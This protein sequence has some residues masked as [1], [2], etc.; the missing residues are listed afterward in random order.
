MAAQESFQSGCIAP[1]T[2][3]GI[4]FQIQIPGKVGGTFKSTRASIGYQLTANVHIRR[5]KEVFVLQHH[6]PVCLFELVQIRAAI[7]IASP[8]DLNP[9]TT[10]TGTSPSL[11]STTSSSP[12]STSTSTSTSNEG[13]RASGVRFVIPKS[14][15]VLGTAEVKPYS[16]WGLGPT[17]S[18]PSQIY[19]HHNYYRYAGNGHGYSYLQDQEHRGSPISSAASASRP[20]YS[21]SDAS[22]E[23]D[24]HH[25]E[26]IK[27]CSTMI[28]GKKAQLQT[29][30]ILSAG[31]QHRRLRRQQQREDQQQQKDSDRRYSPHRDS[32]DG[33]DEVGFGAHIDK[34]VA[35]AG[36]NITLGMFVVKSDGMKVI[37]IKVSLVETIQIFSL[38]DDD[39]G[40]REA[41][42]LASTKDGAGKTRQDVPRRRLVETHV[43][44]I[45]KDYVPAQA[46]ES[47]ANDNHLKGYYE[48]YEDFRS[49][50]SLSVYKLGMHIPETA[51][52]VLDR[53]LFKVEYMFVIKF[54]FKGRMGAF[55][56][57]PI[58][59]ISQY[60]HNRISTNSGAISCVSN[61]VQ[62]AL[63]PVPI[64]VKRSESF[65]SDLAVVTTKRATANEAQAEAAGSDSRRSGNQDTRP[66]DCSKAAEDKANA[67][68]SSPTPTSYSQETPRTPSLETQIRQVENSVPPAMKVSGQ[69]VISREYCTTDSLA[70][71][72][73][74]ECQRHV[75]AKSVQSQADDSRNQSDEPIRASCDV[76]RAEFEVIG[77]N[78]IVG[79]EEHSH[80]ATKADDKEGHPNCDDSLSSTPE[81]HNAGS[82]D[83]VPKIVID[84]VMS[85]LSP[86]DKQVPSGASPKTA[87]SLESSLPLLF[88]LTSAALPTS[89]SLQSSPVPAM[90]ANSNIFRGRSISD[91]SAALIAIKGSSTFAATETQATDGI[92]QHQ[93]LYERLNQRQNTIA[94]RNEES[95]QSHSGLVA[96]IA[97]SL[98]SPV[99]RS[100]ANSASSPDGSTT[101]LST[102]PHQ[103]SS[104]FT[105]AATTLPAL[106]LLSSVGHAAVG[107]EINCNNTGVFNKQRQKMQQS[108]PKPLRS[109]LKKRSVTPPPEHNSST[110]SMKSDGECSL[111]ASQGSINKKKVTFAKGSTPLPSPSGSQVSLA[112]L[113][114]ADVPSAC[115]LKIVDNSQRYDTTLLCAGVPMANSNDVEQSKPIISTQTGV[116]SRISCSP[117]I[118]SPNSASPRTRVHHPFDSHPSR[119]SPLEKQ[120]LDSQI[121][122]LNLSRD[123]KSSNGEV[124]AED[125]EVEEDDDED[126]EHEDNFEDEDDDEK[127]TD[128]QRIERRRLARIAWLAKYGDAFK[129]VYGAVPELPP[130]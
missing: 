38:L 128:D 91:S 114:S 84:S 104:T 85:V 77:R 94:S 56:E 44:K 118:R 60:N 17:T 18:S 28:A 55:L 119:L 39:Q 71:A 96:K 27:Q 34:S 52:T 86:S 36:D 75:P 32:Q 45:A 8:H 98:S 48:D 46:E 20:S 66:V 130:I 109:C 1:G 53:D 61:S 12:S 99:L 41:P 62:I 110:A 13:R 64:L 101:T 121:Q 97:K 82:S 11:S 111:T 69:G 100:R 122:D 127:E 89:T 80:V 25:R 65:S 40:G 10:V 123:Q 5:G 74:K 37:D 22:P 16:L 113:A 49:A 67:H 73:V 88:D 105:L 58:E 23:P 30:E 102:S 6:L 19:N 31:D 26:D 108:P 129:Q 63:P 57:L 78:D 117:T 54:F 43:A 14:N 50:K 21:A 92:G 126:E 76:P 81:R 42:Q 72:E 120:H 115:D 47:H 7:K 90:S 107:H 93:H 29:D 2:Q 35:A 112:G 3:Q 83:T 116:L 9:A 51:L 106:T 87:T 79:K 33:I 125:S 95:T 124:D 68:N 70:C 103:L 4:P 24:L 59:I 15:S